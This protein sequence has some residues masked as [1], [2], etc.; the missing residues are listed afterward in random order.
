MRQTRVDLP[1]NIRH[2]IDF[3]VFTPDNAYFVEAKGRDLDVGKQ[4]RAIVEDLYNVK[5]HV[6]KSKADVYKLFSESLPEF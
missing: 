5:V 1:G 4:K 2:V 6:V 3:F